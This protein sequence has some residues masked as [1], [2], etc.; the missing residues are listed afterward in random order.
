[1]DRK[2]NILKE[3]SNKEEF[4]IRIVEAV[5]HKSGA[6]GL[7]KTITHILKNLTDPNK[8]FILVCQD[9][10]QFTKDYS[11]QRLFAAI[12]EAKEKDA[13]IVC[14]GISWFNNSAQIS[15]HLF[16]V[17]KFSGLQF[18]IV[19]QKFFP[20]ILN[21]DF[22]EV[23]AAD[24]KIS[25]ISANKFFI[26][27][28]ISIQKDYGYSDVTEKNNLAGRV[29]QLFDECIGRINVLTKITQHYKDAV[30]N[31]LDIN[32]DDYKDVA[33]PAYVI[34]LDEKADRKAHIEEQFQNH[35]E[36]DLTFIE[37]S[38]HKTGA[39]GLWLSIRKIVEIAAKNDDDVI[40][41]C[42]EDHLF[43]RE[44]AMQEFIRTV[45]ETSMW[46]AELL[47]GGTI[48]ATLAI[49]I[50]RKLFWVGEFSSTQFLVLFKNIFQ[51]IMDEPFDEK[52]IVAEK[53]SEI[54][55]NKMVFYPFISIQKEFDHSAIPPVNNN[56][57]GHCLNEKK[58]KAAADRLKMISDI[59]K[60]LDNSFPK[61]PSLNEQRYSM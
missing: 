5:R 60:G 43:T 53:L 37:A 56:L 47:I 13:D 42:E 48:D 61:I 34:Q 28:F 36:F 52:A 10:H 18:A 8:D 6:I 46:N 50:T 12:A 49:P 16:W 33:I 26:F 2:E 45:V 20:K 22:N 51:K 15:D 9:D 1:M 14:G 54:A 30:S 38:K 31:T 21:V 59:K 25:A 19:F 17:E 40:I 58:F 11:S 39:V 32:M 23:E 44:Y 55:S 24:Y 35:K 3:F 7:W 41:I 29:T 27:P 4:A 57:R